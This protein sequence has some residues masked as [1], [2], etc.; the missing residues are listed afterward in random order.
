MFGLYE[1]SFVQLH[2]LKYLNETFHKETNEHASHNHEDINEL[3]SFFL[4]QD[5]VFYNNLIG[6]YIHK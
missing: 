3:F 5:S 6:F 4:L 1:R 2:D